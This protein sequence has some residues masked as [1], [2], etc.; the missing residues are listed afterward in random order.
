L[1]S[2]CVRQLVNSIPHNATRWRIFRV[3]T[4]VMGL[5]NSPL[6]VL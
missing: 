6:H 3:V 5:L 2:E 1:T 4:D